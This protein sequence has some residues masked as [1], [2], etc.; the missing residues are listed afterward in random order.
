MTMIETFYNV[1]YAMSC[2]VQTTQVFQ[3]NVRSHVF[4]SDESFAL[5]CPDLPELL[6]AK[7]SSET[8]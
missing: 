3:A 8:T 4:W 6:D 2:S 7:Y 1:S 5:D